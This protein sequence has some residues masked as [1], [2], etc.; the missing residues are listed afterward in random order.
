MGFV[1]GTRACPPSTIAGSTLCWINNSL[2]HFVLSIV[3]TNQN[4]RTTWLALERRYASTSHNIILHLPNELLRTTTVSAVQAPDTL[5]TY[6]TFEALLLTTKRQMLEQV[7][8][9]P[10]NGL[11][12][13]GHPAVDCLQ[14]MNMAY[15]AEFRLSTSLPWPYLLALQ[16]INQ[17]DPSFLTQVQ[18]RTSLQI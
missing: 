9:M 4:A 17:M 13:Y 11:V 10:N 15:E 5:I 6:D 1:D 8:L 18:M 3:L 16:P 2:T 7:V 14:I 12:G